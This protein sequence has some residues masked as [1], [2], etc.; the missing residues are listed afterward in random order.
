[1]QIFLACNLLFL[2]E[3]QKIDKNKCFRPVGFAPE[4]AATYA[5]A[6]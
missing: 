1:M 2:K 5:A 6:Q 4:D 3:T